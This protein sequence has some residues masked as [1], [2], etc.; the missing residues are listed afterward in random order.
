MAPCHR[1]LLH[2]RR[3]GSGVGNALLAILLD[4]LAQLVQVAAIRVAIDGNAFAALATKE[5]EERHVSHFA[6]DV[7]QRHVDAGDRVVL[8]RTVTPVSI[9]VHQ[10]P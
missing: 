10:L 5:L 2:S 7:P 4:V 9:L 6:L 3:F 8:D 1:R